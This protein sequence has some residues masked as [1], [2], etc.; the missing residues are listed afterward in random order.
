M[1]ISKSLDI[2]VV[3]GNLNAKVGSKRHGDIVGS[4]WLGTKTERGDRLIEWAQMNNLS[5][6]H[7]GYGHGRV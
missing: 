7:E 4:H 2:T 5:S 6:I 1:N 3:M